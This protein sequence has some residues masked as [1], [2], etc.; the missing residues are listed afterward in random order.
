MSLSSLSVTALARHKGAAALSSSLCLGK[1][2]ALHCAAYIY[3]SRLFSLSQ[4]DL[5]IQPYQS[6]RCVRHRHPPLTPAMAP[7]KVKTPP[8]E[9]SAIMPSPHSTNEAHGVDKEQ[10]AVDQVKAFIQRFRADR[11]M[12]LPSESLSYNISP[13]D[14]FGLCKEFDLFED[15]TFP[16][17]TYNA[18]KSI[19]T[20]HGIPS[21]V[22]DSVVQFLFRSLGKAID[23]DGKIDLSIHLTT[24]QG[25]S[26]KA[27]TSYLERHQI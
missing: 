19:L 5:L 26:S 14:W 2:V 13:R 3:L 4:I 17:Y 11:L 25:I 8:K 12:A 22:H 27:D 7:Q 23:H 16:R 10:G 1:A 9:P 20:I 24:N 15:E 21:P 18:F 6:K